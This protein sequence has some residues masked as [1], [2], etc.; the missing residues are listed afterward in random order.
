MAKYK[1]GGRVH[2][3]TE[4]M[5]D[6]HY[7]PG[8]KAPHPGIYRCIVCNHEIAIAKDHV[9]PPENPDAR[10]GEHPLHSHAGVPEVIM[11]ELLVLSEGK[12]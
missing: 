1:K 2:E 9:L 8:E 3:S 5:F 11:W 7:P 12:L 10:L 4:S 6:K